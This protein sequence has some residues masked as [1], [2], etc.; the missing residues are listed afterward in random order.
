MQKVITI[1]TSAKAG[2]LLALASMSITPTKTED[3]NGATEI[4]VDLTDDQIKTLE[5]AFNHDNATVGMIIRDGVDKIAEV[6][7]DGVDF[8]VNDFA[9]PVATIGV[10]A[11]ASVG[12][13]AVKAVAQTGASVINN[14]VDEGVK[15]VH[16]VKTNDECM[17]LK[18]SW[19][20]VKGLFSSKPKIK[21]S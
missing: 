14:L 20:T 17:K 7:T 19:A 11:G 8:A 3:K 12:R 15:A 21:I 2:L 13:I 5:T 18:Q 6:V 10:K 16:G 9:I 1:E 4:T